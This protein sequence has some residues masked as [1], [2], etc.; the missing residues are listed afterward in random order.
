MQPIPSSS[1]SPKPVPSGPTD[2]LPSG[3]TSPTGTPPTQSDTPSES[4][5]EVDP[6]VSGGVIW[7]VSQSCELVKHYGDS[8]DSPDSPDG[9]AELGELKDYPGGYYY[10]CRDGTVPDPSIL[11]GNEVVVPLNGFNGGGQ[12]TG[13]GGHVDGAKG[14]NG[15]TW[16]RL[17][18][19]SPDTPDTPDSPD[20]QPEIPEIPEIE[21][22]P[23]DPRYHWMC[24]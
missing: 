3:T 11:P 22:D 21:Q 4:K 6:P 19:D 14:P 20:G 13:G 15:C 17:F 23:A 1:E 10:L 7:K 5:A 8:P 9:Q 18:G 2:T 12:V 24:V 16:R